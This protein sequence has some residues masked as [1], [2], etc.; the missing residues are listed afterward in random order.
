V[1][2]PVIELEPAVGD[3]KWNR[4]G[5]GPESVPHTLAGQSERTVTAPVDEVLGEGDPDAEHVVEGSGHGPRE[6]HVT[7]ADPAWEDHHVLVVRQEH[8]PV[9]FE[10]PE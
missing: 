8:H 3:S 9:A 7:A 4:A 1:V 5:A 10:G 2:H 6:G